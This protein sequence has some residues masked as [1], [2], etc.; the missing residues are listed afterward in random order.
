[1]YKLALYTH[2]HTHTGKFWKLQFCSCRCMSTGPALPWH[3]PAGQVRVKVSDGCSRLHRCHYSVQ[4]H[5]VLRA[6]VLGYVED[7]NCRGTRMELMSTKPS[8]LTLSS[9]LFYVF[10]SFNEHAKK[11]DFFF[12]ILIRRP[13]IGKSWASSENRGRGVLRPPTREDG[14][15]M[16]FSLQIFPD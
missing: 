4:M 15:S 12:F 5:G 6:G 16:P 14:R 10:L 7:Q 1:M 11:R 2:T 13:L 3:C 9:V 8:F